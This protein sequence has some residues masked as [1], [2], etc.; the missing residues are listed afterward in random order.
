MENNYFN[1]IAGYDNLKEELLKIS[2]WYLKADEYLKKGIKIP[3]GFIFYGPTGTGKSKFI[4][5]FIKLF[6]Y[7]VYY[8]NGAND[9][10]SQEMID[11][12]KAA[13]QNKRS[14]II[15]D[16]LDLLIDKDR[17]LVR[18]LQ[19]EMDKAYEDA[20]VIMFATTNNFALI[21]SPLLRGG[22][23]ERKY[24]VDNPK[25]YD[26]KQL[27]KYFLSN[28]DY[29]TSGNITITSDDIDIDYLS[30]ILI[31]CSGAFIQTIINDAYIRSDGYLTTEKIE[32]AYYILQHGL[33][34]TKICNCVNKDI[35]S[36][37]EVGHAIIAYKNKKYFTFYKAYLHSNRNQ[38]AMCEIFPTDEEDDNSENMIAQIEISLG[39]YV[40]N[41]YLNKVIMEGSYA[42]LFKAKRLSRLL[43][44]V[45]GYKGIKY[46]L[47]KYDPHSRNETELNCYKNDILSTKL[48][49]KCEKNVKKYLKKNKNNIYKLSNI[50]ST[51]GILTAKDL[52]NVLESK[53]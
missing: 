17:K 12:L 7:P 50:L 47:K 21:P 5:E 40:V 51:K 19:T 8:L 14:I 24:E 44:N 32:N 27:L 1:N 53:K 33:S 29:G 2:K 46:V 28:L 31:N 9:N 3:I 30:K 23:F 4:K 43:I 38:K 42:D 35:V 11:L 20:S 25:E 36:M 41:K 22:R 6:S 49:L 45:L 52:I 26:R 16:E 37:H 48:L 18:I 10:S 13:K 15:I 34:N 39:G